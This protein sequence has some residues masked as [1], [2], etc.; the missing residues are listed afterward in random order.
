MRTS[1][2]AAV[3]CTSLICLGWGEDPQPT[4]PGMGLGTE[5]INY[6]FHLCLN[7]LT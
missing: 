1:A 2:G 6:I 3:A 4:K 5:A 7:F